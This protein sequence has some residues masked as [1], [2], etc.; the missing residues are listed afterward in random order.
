MVDKVRRSLRNAARSARRSRSAPL[1][2]GGDQLVV[3]AVAATQPQ[4]TEGQ[5]AALQERVELVLNELRQVGACSVFGLG[6]EGRGA[7]LHWAGTSPRRERNRCPLQ[8]RTRVRLINTN[9]TDGDPGGGH[10]GSDRVKLLRFTQG[11]GA[12]P[13][14]SA[15]VCAGCKALSEPGLARVSGPPPLFKKPTGLGWFFF[16][17]SPQCWRGFRALPRERQPCEVG[18]FAP[19]EASLFSVFSGGHASVLEATSFA[20]AGLEEVGCGWQLL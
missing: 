16:V 20:G 11:S 15:R 10:R 6:D 18:V 14:R 4:E 1:A 2:I 8:M 12:N 7:L 17:C 13:H 19:A 9:R 3:V 5:D